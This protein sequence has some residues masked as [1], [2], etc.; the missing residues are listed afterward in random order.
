VRNA[1][2]HAVTTTVTNAGRWLLVTPAQNQN[3]NQTVVN[4]ACGSSVASETIH[5]YCR[6]AT[7]RDAWMAAGAALI[8]GQ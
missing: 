3:Q 1:V 6:R 7:A 5:R 8:G 2:C 4:A